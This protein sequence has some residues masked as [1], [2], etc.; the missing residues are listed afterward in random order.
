ML[1]MGITAAELA[2]YMSK[3]ISVVDGIL[4]CYLIGTSW[5]TVVHKDEGIVIFEIVAMIGAFLTSVFV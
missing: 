4:V 3:P 2:I 1:L 5:A